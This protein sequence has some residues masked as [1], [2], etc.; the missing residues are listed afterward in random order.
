[1][2]LV[3]PQY[4]CMQH[5][6]GEHAEMHMFAGCLIKKK[7]LSGYIKNNLFEPK[8][9]LVRHDE[10]AEELLER[11]YKHQTPL[12]DYSLDHLPIRERNAY[13]IRLTSLYNLLNR[14]PSCKRRYMALAGI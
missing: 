4:M 3:P 1:M 10:L 13:V 8:L 11:F 7:P 2:W 6:L 14:C 5:L 9:L 12:P